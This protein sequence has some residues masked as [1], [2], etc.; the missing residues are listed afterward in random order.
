MK[1]WALAAALALSASGFAN[2]AM[3]VPVQWTLTGMMFEDGATASGSF[4]YDADTGT[5]TNVNITTTTAGGF[6][7]RTYSHVCGP[8]CDDQSGAG[9]FL[10]LTQAS[11]TSAEGLEVLPVSVVPALT[12]AGGTGSIS[13]AVETTCANPE[14]STNA[15]DAPIRHMEFSGTLEASPYIP[16]HTVTAVPTLSHLSLGLMSLALGGLAWLRRKV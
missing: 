7:G 1:K 12:N 9:W 4:V 16:P 13:F 14:C 6:A 2:T 15:P 10:F 5:V 8:V 3:A 11:G